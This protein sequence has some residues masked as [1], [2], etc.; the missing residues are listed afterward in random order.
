MENTILRTPILVYSAS[1]GL[2]IGLNYVRNVVPEDRKTVNVRDNIAH[3][4][5]LVSHI[6]G[7]IYFVVGRV[8]DG[9]GNSLCTM[10]SEGGTRLLYGDCVRDRCG[11]NRIVSAIMARLRSFNTFYSVNYNG[12]TLLPVSTVS[13]SHVTRPGSHFRMNSGVGTIVGDVTSSKGVALSRGR[14]LNA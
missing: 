3:S 4:V 2:V 13:I 5:T 12:V 8:G 6:K 14:L 7:P 11:V 10:L 1:R 9:R